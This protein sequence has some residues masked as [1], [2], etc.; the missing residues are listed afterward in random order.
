MRIGLEFR[1]SCWGLVLMLAVACLPWQARGEELQIPKCEEAWCFAVAQPPSAWP[2][3]YTGKTVDVQEIPRI[4]IDIPAGIKKIVRSD[5]VTLIMYDGKKVLSL[6]EHRKEDYADFMKAVAGTN[7]NLNDFMHV[8]FTKTPKD[9]EPEAA[10]DQTF[11]RLA[12]RFKSTYMGEPE[13]RVFTGKKGA[14]TVYYKKESKPI[15]GNQENTAI[16]LNE[17]SP[18]AFLQISS[19]NMSFD[20][21]SKIIGTIRERIVK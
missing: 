16:V 14:V 11:W 20:E 9:K 17:K 1:R 6:S 5:S 7:Y 15:L 19:T 3:A 21:F 4:L 8:V 18:A 10:A 12:M 13:T 2:A